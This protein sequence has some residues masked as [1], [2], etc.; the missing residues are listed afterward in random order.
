VKWA[1]FA[2]G[3]DTTFSATIFATQLLIKRPN[4]T[5]LRRIGIGDLGP[6]SLHN[7]D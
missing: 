2:E 5:V 1:G 7:W 4:E 3:Q 6:I